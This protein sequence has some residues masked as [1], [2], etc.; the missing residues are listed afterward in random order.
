MTELFVE[1]QDDEEEVEYALRVIAL[2]HQ[3]G[4]RVWQLY[5]APP[6]MR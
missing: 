3:C 4:F 6:S 5:V 2:L 1:D